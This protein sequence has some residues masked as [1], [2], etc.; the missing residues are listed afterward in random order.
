[1][2]ISNK[3]KDTLDDLINSLDTEFLNRPELINKEIC[4]APRSKNASPSLLEENCL[5]GNILVSSL[6]LAPK[7]QDF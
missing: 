4:N 5:D 3:N 2:A 7:I 1:M 6:K